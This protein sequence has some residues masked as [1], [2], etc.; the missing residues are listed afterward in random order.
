MD[1]IDE[2]KDEEDPKKAII[3]VARS[4]VNTKTEFYA[5][6]DRLKK[7][8]T[9]VREILTGNG[10]PDESLIARVGC[11]E[12]REKLLEENVE[13]INSLLLGDMDESRPS[14][15]DRVRSNEKV[16]ATLQKITWLLVSVALAEI[17]LRLLEIL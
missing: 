3:M 1:I 6:E 11:I 16:V 17:V 12:R 7:D 10:N 4:L 13:K 15:L 14:L 2:I 5:C 8:I 9:V